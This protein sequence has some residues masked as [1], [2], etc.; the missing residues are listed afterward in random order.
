MNFSSKTMQW[1][2]LL[3]EKRFHYE[4]LI[5]SSDQ[6]KYIPGFSHDKTSGISNFQDDIERIIYSSA[7]RRLQGKTQVRAF[8][9]SDYMRN[10]L[11][12]SI[13]VSYVGRVLG[14]LIG[15]WLKR[16]KHIPDEFE[17]GAIGDVVHAA[18]LIHDLGNPPFGHVGEYAIRAWFTEHKKNSLISEALKIKEHRH[19]FELFDG[20]AQAFR[21]VTQ[22][23]N[24]RH[25]GGL[26]LTF[27]VIG[28]FMKYPFTATVGKK[29][30]KKQK[31]GTLMADRQDFKTIA[32]ELGL[33]RRRHEKLDSKNVMYLDYCRHPLSFLSECADDICYRTTDIEDAVKM[34]VISFKRGEDLLMNVTISKYRQNYDSIQK[35]HESDRIS[36]LRSAAISSLIEDV[37]STFIQKYDQIIT[38]TLD[39]NLL[40]YGKYKS[41]IKDI[42]N[43]CRDKIY[44]ERKKLEIEI[45]GY[46]IIHNLMSA[47][48]DVFES[49]RTNGDYAIG[50]RQ[51]ALYA[52]LPREITS[53]ASRSPYDLCVQMTDIVSG[54]TDRYAVTAWKQI[55]GYEL[56]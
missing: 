30:Y 8:P 2:K 29:I 39:G 28:S 1:D 23:Q 19:D 7:F 3:V 37:V 25:D 4:H 55:A 36:Y 35:D 45:G 17:P 42:S 27:P 24:W 12:H 14:R 26:R 32:E 10:R 34:G 16:G 31:F 40:D 6:N 54:M 50:S 44:V 21:I 51:L 56:N 38:G 46:N 48:S 53:K 22:L 20:N 33:L 18:C 41:N 49:L 13:E 15:S 5:G 52:L 43:T 47:Y 9:N 11:T